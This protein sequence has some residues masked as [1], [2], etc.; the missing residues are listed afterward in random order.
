MEFSSLN[1][2]FDMD[3]TLIDSTQA[4]IKA[5]EEFG[6]QNGF[7]Y[8]DEM[9]RTVKTMKFYD[10]CLYLCGFCNLSPET[11]AEQYFLLL[12]K[13]YLNSPLMDGAYEFVT[14][15]RNKG[16]KMCVLTSGIRRLAQAA[17]EH[18]GLFDYFDFIATADELAIDKSEPESFRECCRKLNAA[19]DETIVFE[20]SLY[21]ARAALTAGCR[22]IGMENP[23]NAA[24]HE[25]LKSIAIQTIKDFKG[26]NAEEFYFFP[27]ETGENKTKKLS[28]L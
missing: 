9:Y 7:V 27:S 19:P 25:E 20:D 4:W 12:E 3:G 15:C 5:D 23:K 28:L 13:N 26:L 10:A 14:D 2:I 6:E 24:E 8:T 22:V 18:Y 21:A 17:L 11:A 1:I 16:I